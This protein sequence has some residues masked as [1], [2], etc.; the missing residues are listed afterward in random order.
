MGQSVLSDFAYVGGRPYIRG[1]DLLGH[2][3]QS[4]V[5]HSEK[6]PL[7]LV[8]LKLLREL[9]CN[10]IWED[11]DDRCLNVSP[12]GPSATLE[13]I[14]TG[15]VKRRARFMET[16]SLITRT[17]PNVSAL[18]TEIDWKDLFAGHAMIP[19]PAD[20]ISVLDG[21]VA[22]NKAFHAETLAAKGLAFDSIRFIYIEHF[23][24]ITILQNNDVKIEV[25]HRGSKERGGRTYTFNFADFDSNYASARVNICYSFNGRI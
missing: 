24:I 5:P 17:S 15:G 16:D 10:G 14:D 22:A 23:P 6:Y 4:K 3:L 2:F 18:T 25:T 8:S 1:V 11:E 13:Y 9:K 20:A 7:E 12:S 21:L 19:R